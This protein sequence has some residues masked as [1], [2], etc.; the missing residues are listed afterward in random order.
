MNQKLQSAALGYNV[1]EDAK[2]LQSR[3]A[4][5]IKLARRF[6]GGKVEATSRVPARGRLKLRWLQES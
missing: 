2:L 1:A 6:N 4:G 5:R 3:P